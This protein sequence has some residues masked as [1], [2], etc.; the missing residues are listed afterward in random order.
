MGPRGALLSVRAVDGATHQPLTDI[1]VN[2]RNSLNK[3]QGGAILGKPREPHELLIPSHSNVEIQVRARGYR[4]SEFVPVGPL[5]A[6]EKQDLTIS[7][8]RDSAAASIR[9]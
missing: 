3:G 2:F 4:P 7:L 5:A 8:Q 9:Q 6:G 1:A